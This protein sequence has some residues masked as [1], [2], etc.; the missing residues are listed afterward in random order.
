MAKF[1]R[2]CGKPVKEGA[3][4][5]KTCGKPL[6]RKNVQPV[7]QRPAD[8]LPVLQNPADQAPT[9]QAAINKADNTSRPEITTPSETKKSVI[10][11]M[12]KPKHPTGIMAG[13][14]AGEFGVGAFYFNANPQGLAG[15]GVKKAR[16]ILSPAKTFISGFKGIGGKL[17]HLFAG[18]NVKYMIPSPPGSSVHGIVHQ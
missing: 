6:A 11:E 9:Q 3:K 14:A 8:K 12:P 1:C 5:C 16:E 7:Q 10:P 4:F 2:Y 18:K 15:K 13:A 17:K